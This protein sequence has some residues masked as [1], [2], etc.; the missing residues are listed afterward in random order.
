MIK[1]SS[2]MKKKSGVN[3]QKGNTL[4]YKQFTVLYGY[5]DVNGI[6]VWH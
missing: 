4:L 3:L 6:N 5:F 2:T 1:I